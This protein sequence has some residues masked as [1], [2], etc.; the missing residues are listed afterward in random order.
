MIHHHDSSEE[1]T[2]AGQSS[3]DVSPNVSPRL[4]V[5]QPLKYGIFASPNSAQLEEAFKKQPEVLRRPM[6]VT[7]GVFSKPLLDLIHLKKVRFNDFNIVHHNQMYSFSEK[8]SNHLIH[9]RK[10]EYH[11]HNQSYLTRVYPAALRVT[12]SNYDP[13]PHWEAGC[14]LV[15]LNFQTFATSTIVDS[16]GLTSTAFFRIYGSRLSW[17]LFR[18]IK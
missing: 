5:R 9:K 13:I 1:E 17:N 3:L 2:D 14:Q 8:K 7:K 12:S 11:Q 4:S 15:S 16:Q 10:E 18:L 6:S